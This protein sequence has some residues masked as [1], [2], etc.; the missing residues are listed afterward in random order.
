MRAAHSNRPSPAPNGSVAEKGPL[1]P[2]RIDQ[3]VCKR[4]LE[5]FH[6]EG[7]YLVDKDRLTIYY[8]GRDSGMAVGPG[9]DHTVTELIPAPT[10]VLGVEDHDESL[11]GAPTHLSLVNETGDRSALFGVSLVRGDTAEGSQV[12]TTISPVKNQNG[13]TVGAMQVFQDREEISL[14]QQRL[15]ELER[16]VLLDPLTRVGNRRYAEMQLQCCLDEMRRYGWPFGVLFIDVDDFKSINDTFGHATGDAVLRVTSHTLVSCLRSSDVVSRWGGE[17]FVVVL[18]N[19][20]KEQ[21]ERIAE[22]VR[23]IVSQLRIP[24]DH[25]LLQVTVSVGATVA[26]ADDSVASLVNRADRL[27][28]ESKQAGRNR[29]TVDGTL[30]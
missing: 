9:S 14:L 11:F 12:F 7:I 20:G 15:Q 23:S 10:S 25:D 18:K 5:S 6:D 13:E 1:S 21:I 4:A 29:V 8:M 28:Y 30:A 24:V 2:M 22:K 19:I 16:M 27:M 17:E 26:G 3:D